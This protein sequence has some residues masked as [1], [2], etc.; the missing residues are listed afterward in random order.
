MKSALVLG[1]TRFFGVKLVQALLE[2]GVKVTVATRGNTEVPFY[3]QVEKIQFDRSN[4]AS[5]H[6]AFEGRKWDIIYDQIC[7][8]S[9]EAK[10]AISVFSNKTDKYVFTSSLSVYELKD[11]ILEES[12][13]DPYTYPV[14]Y[15]ESDEVTYNEGKRLAEA[16][17]FQES[18]F[19]VT[20]VRF[21]I[22][23]GEQDYTERMLFYI[24]KALHDEVIYL[25]NPDASICFIS[26]E[27]A[28]D[29]LAWI[30]LQS[31]SGPINACTNGS[32][33]LNEFIEYIN[34]TTHKRAHVQQSSDDSRSTPYSIP[35]NWVMSNEKARSLG[36]RFKELKEYLPD[37]IQ[38]EV[39]KLKG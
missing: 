38:T 28:G 39:Q 2:K 27:E 4:S 34:E 37:I 33:R 7:Y 14:R 10:N 19:P 24:R 26:E 22:V 16:V 31:Y 6:S 3:D 17:F 30:G 13:F 36:Y 23:L 5:F 18:P 9:N 35:G 1:G 21:P 15:T 12:D 8:S 11:K 29:F 20:A 25:R 32:V